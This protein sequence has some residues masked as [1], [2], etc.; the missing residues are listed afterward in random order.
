[1]S[2]RDELNSIGYRG[3]LFHYNIGGLQEQ[4]GLSVSFEL[5]ESELCV[6]LF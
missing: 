4:W 3:Q 5:N 2:K 6:V 1:M